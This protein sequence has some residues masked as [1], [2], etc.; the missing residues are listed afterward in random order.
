MKCL[1]LPVRAC[2]K[3]LLLVAWVW[4][5]YRQTHPPESCCHWNFGAR[6]V[7]RGSSK[8]THRKD[9]ALFRMVWDDRF[10]SDRALAVWMR[11]WYGMRAGQKTINN[12]LLSRGYRAC[13]PTR[14][15]LLS[16]DHTYLGLEWAQGWQNLTMAHRQHVIFGDES[17]FQLY[18][19]D[20]KLRIRRLPGERFQQR[21]QA[22]RVQA[23]GDSVHIWEAFH[24]GAKSPFVLPNRYLT[25]ELYRG[26]LQN[27]IEH[28]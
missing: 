12:R 6:Q 26:I 20:G 11:N 24:S 27:P 22:Y 2:G 3:V 4:L 18:L 21:C 13:K 19:V 23:G 17:R 16:S 5:V 1:H 7:P 8:T 14:N 28:I 10:L 25:G 9:R 15:P